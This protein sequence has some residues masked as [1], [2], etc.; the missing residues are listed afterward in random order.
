MLH[1][2]TKGSNSKHIIF[3]HGNSQSL[4]LWDKTVSENCLKEEYT[5]VTVDLPGHGKS[6]RSKEPNKDYCI[7]GMAGYL[8]D[9]ILQY[10][11]RPY[12]VVANSLGSNLVG[13]V[14]DK[15]TNCKG[16]FLTGACI[17]GE[18]I[19]PAAIFQPNPN[20]APFFTVY[21]TDEAIDKMITDGLCYPKEEIIVE[22]KSAFKNTD[23]AFRESL[24]ASIAREEWSDE[25]NNLANLTIPIAIVF[26]AEERFSVIDYLQNTSFPKW[27][28][29]IVTVP[30]ASHLVQYDQP[31]LLARLIKEFAED[32]F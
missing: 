28:G 19:M 2:E 24:V 7:Q 32:C 21:P 27:R 22:N 14:A 29:T 20:L 23:P 31:A 15:L 1:S 16:I 5:L 11:N 3:V 4:S 26:G 9:F 8:L 10:N 30:D 12:I 17:L 18:G 13:E 6:F 25:I